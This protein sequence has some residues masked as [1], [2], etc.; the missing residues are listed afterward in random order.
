MGS[1]RYRRSSLRTMLGITK[2]E[3]R[4]KQRLG[5]YKVTRVLNAPKNFRR[6]VLRKLGYYSEPMKF[7]RYWLRR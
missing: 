4:V 6:R 5:I 2:A 7:L 3:R 1:F